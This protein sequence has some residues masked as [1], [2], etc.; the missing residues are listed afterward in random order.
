MGSG[1]WESHH[2]ITRLLY[3]Y[4]TYYNRGLYEK[5]GALFKHAT[6][7]TK[8]PWSDEGHGVQRGSEVTENFKAMVNLYEGLPRVQMSLSNIIL[9]IDE[10]DGS[11]ESWS[12]YFGLYGPPGTWSG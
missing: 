8:Y 4:H 10:D 11:A 7:Q 3:E 9:D 5:M 1:T 2:A 6:Y 12:Q